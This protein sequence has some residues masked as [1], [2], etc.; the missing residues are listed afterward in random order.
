VAD[1]FER[2]LQVLNDY[3][4]L[5]LWVAG[6]AAAIPFVAQFVGV[7]PPFPEGVA[8]ITAV[9]QLVALAITFHFVSQKSRAFVNGL[10]MRTALLIVA[11]ILAYMIL[12][13]SFVIVIGPDQTLVRGFT[14]TAEALAQFRSECPFLSRESVASALYI[15]E[16]LWTFGSLVAS[17]LSLFFVWLAFFLAISVFFAAFITYQRKG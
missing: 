13:S 1:G 5:S 17:R 12:F 4:S 3:K 7:E 16:D 9:L 10:M 14:C 6:G 15:E 11:L 2:F 8:P